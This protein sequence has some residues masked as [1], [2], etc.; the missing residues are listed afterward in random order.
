MEPTPK[1]DVTLILLT[2][3]ESRF[4][5]RLQEVVNLP[6]P[7]PKRLYSAANANEGFSFAADIMKS[8]IRG[9]I[10]ERKRDPLNTP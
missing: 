3:R 7:Y 9:T 6:N 4:S 1:S 5:R 8:E 10:S 2:G